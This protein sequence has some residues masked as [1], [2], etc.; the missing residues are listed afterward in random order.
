MQL[1]GRGLSVIELRYGVKCA[2]LAG[3]GRCMESS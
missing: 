1:A 2:W 3:S